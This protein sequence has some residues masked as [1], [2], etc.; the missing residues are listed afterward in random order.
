MQL[1]LCKNNVIAHI[2]QKVT[3]TLGIKVYFPS[4]CNMID[5]NFRLKESYILESK[6]FPSFVNYSLE[7]GEDSSA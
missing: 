3:Y 2:S 4:Y 6:K 7:L 1:S 5:G